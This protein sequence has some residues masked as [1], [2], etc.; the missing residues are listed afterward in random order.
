V[1]KAQARAQALSNLA[2]AELVMGELAEAVEHLTAALLMH[3]ETGNLWG[4]ANTLFN[5][6]ILDVQRGD[7]DRGLKRALEAVAVSRGAAQPRGRSTSSR[8]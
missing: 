7:P 1:G 8:A 4:L 6:S 2:A 3:R 5:L